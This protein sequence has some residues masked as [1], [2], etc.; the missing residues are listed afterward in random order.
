MRIGAVAAVLASTAALAAC[1]AGDPPALNP[2]ADAPVASTS[3]VATATATPQ[4]SLASA[5]VDP[6]VYAIACDPAGHARPDAVTVLSETQYRIGGW[7]HL[8]G[9]GTF[10]SARLAPTEYAISA[11]AFVE[12][13]DCDGQRAL[14]TV[15][16]KKTYDWDR[17]HANGMEASFPAES[18]TFGEVSDIVLELRVDAA[19]TAIPSASDLA[20]AYGDVLD[21]K[22]LGELDAQQINLELT[23]YGDGAGAGAQTMNAGIIVAVDP[24]EFADGWVRV[25][26]PRED[27]TFYTE[28]DYVR[29]EVA[30]DAHA[31]LLVE[32]L[33]INPETA[34]GA[35]VRRLVTGVGGEFDPA[36]KPELLK[37]MG[38][39]FALIQVGRSA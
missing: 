13:P 21:E 23:L 8:N 31:T 15:L 29:T 1:S 39:T 22:Q 17:Q 20:A 27:L 18:L 33:R 35:T 37:E 6:G 2:T 32:G 38:L 19:T 26:V 9:V 7:N 11:Q 36:A 24:A 3:P 25:A 5:A 14:E 4:P 12:Q 30:P 10:A 34:T 16:V 28:T